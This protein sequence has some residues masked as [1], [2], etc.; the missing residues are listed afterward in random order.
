MA[1]RVLNNPKIEMVWDTAVE[2]IV[3]DVSGKFPKMTGLRVKNLKTGAETTLPAEAMFVAIGHTPNSA[4][5]GGAV[6]TE[7]TGYLVVNE[8]QETSVEGVYAAG[9]IHDHTYRQA[10]T[11][12]GFGCKASLEV[13]RYLTRKGLSAV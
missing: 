3:G 9:D 1:E 13:E 6:K 4:F 2:E 11:A 7:D 12:A 10:I 5:L 8:A